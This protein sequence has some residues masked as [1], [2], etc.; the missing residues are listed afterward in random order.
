MTSCRGPSPG[1][2]SD[3]GLA[4]PTPMS[5]VCQSFVGGGLLKR[6]PR[7]EWGQGEL[8]SAVED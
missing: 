3:L 5:S 7:E 8:A 6:R 2:L 4:G 1:G